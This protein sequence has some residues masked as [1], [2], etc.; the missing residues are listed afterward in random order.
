MDEARLGL[1]FGLPA[2]MSLKGQS[3]PVHQFRFKAAELES[4]VDWETTRYLAAATQLNLRY[5]RRVVRRVIGEPLLAVAPAAGANVVVVSRWALDSLRRRARRDGLLA[6]MLI[7]GVFVALLAATWIPLAAMVGLAIPVIAY[8]R[9]VRDDKIIVGLML[10]G[11]FRACQAPT[12]PNPRI[13]KRLAVVSEQQGGNLVVFRGQSAFVGSG[14]GVF[15]YRMVI[16]VALGKRGKDGERER[17]IPFTNPELHAELEKALKGM[18]FPELRVRERLF[19]NGRHV[20]GYSRLLPNELAPPVA[21]APPDLLYTGCI[22]PTP[23]ARTYLCAEIGGWEGQLVVSLFARAMQACGSLQVEWRFKILPP[24]HESFLHIDHWYE[25]SKATQVVTAMIA[26]FAWSV[27][28]LVASPVQIGR[29][30]SVPLFD[31]ARERRQSYRIRH[32]YVFNYGSRRSI[33]ELATGYTRPHY[34]LTQDELTFALLAE[35]TMFQ[36]LRGFLEDHNIDMEQFN[37][38][39]RTFINNVSNYNIGSIRAGNVAVG[40]KSRAGGRGKSDSTGK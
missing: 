5:A 21:S 3:L 12:F 38:Q 9:W 2:G 20:A 28:A 4:E 31:Q 40:N 39:E 10:R 30:A 8:E 6:G 22:N 32:G 13:E 36:A 33:R 16:N 17:P 1:E 23:D 29:Y 26:G 15:H 37:A 19:V 14:N 27:P 11:R 7:L 24:L 18:D 34:F 25:R 35:S